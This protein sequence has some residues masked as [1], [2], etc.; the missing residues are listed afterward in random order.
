MAKIS[1]ILGAGIV[2]VLQLDDRGTLKRLGVSVK[3]RG[4]ARIEVTGDRESLLRLR[5]AC[6]SATW[7]SGP[8]WYSRSAAAAFAEIEKVLQ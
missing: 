5:E 7:Y 8:P 1:V 3:S 6:R 4:K 2:Q